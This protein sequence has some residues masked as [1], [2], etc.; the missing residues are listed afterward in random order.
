VQLEW[1]D[2]EHRLS[3]GGAS[4]ESPLLRVV[5]RFV[6][7]GEGTY[8]FSSGSLGDVEPF[9]NPR[10]REPH[11]QL[12]RYAVAPAIF[13]GSVFTHVARSDAGRN[14]QE[15]FFIFT[16]RRDALYLYKR[17]GRLLIV[18]A[19]HNPWIPA[20]RTAFGGL[21]RSVEN[22]LIAVDDESHWCD[23][24]SAVRGDI[25]QLARSSAV[26]K[27]SDD[28]ISKPSHDCDVTAGAVRTA[29]SPISWCS[30]RRPPCGGTSAMS[31]TAR[32]S[33]RQRSRGHNGGFA[34]ARSLT[35]II[36]RLARTAGPR[37]GRRP[38][39]HPTRK[40]HRSNG[41]R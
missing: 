24:W 23:E 13:I 32:L 27:E 21:F 10:R 26:G 3:F 11:D 25:A 6:T 31:T 37:P 33:P 14:C 5:R 4:A 2:S 30:F 38:P 8:K 17:V 41:L 18:D 34:T 1:P 39:G 16:G 40:A 12:A 28:I 36:T 29:E 20:Q 9:D 7:D 35:T 19:Q 22:Q 15:L